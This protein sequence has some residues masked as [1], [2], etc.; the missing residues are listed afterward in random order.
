MEVHVTLPEPQ[1]RE[2]ASEGAITEPKGGVASC[3][4]P[5]TSEPEPI[6]VEIAGFRLEEEDSEKREDC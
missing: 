1:L 2:N 4:G 5:S 3:D 6:P